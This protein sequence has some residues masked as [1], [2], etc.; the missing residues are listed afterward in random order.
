MKEKI[1]DQILSS[2]S[3]KEAMVDL[4]IDDIES[5]ANLMIK[6]IQNGGKI[7][8]CGNRSE[9]ARQTRFH[10]PCAR[11]NRDGM[12]LA[13]FFEILEIAIFKILDLRNPRFGVFPPT[14]PSLLP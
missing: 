7:L 14:S 10:A 9:R 3:M 13:Q 5:A 6:S 12:T 8:W 4:C 11:T 1:K 2:V